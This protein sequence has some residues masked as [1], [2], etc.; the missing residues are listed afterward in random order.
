MIKPV[1]TTHDL[2]L[3]KERLVGLIRSNQEGSFTDEIEVLSTLIE[4]YERATIQIAAASPVEAIR[5][6][7]DQQGLAPRQLE[8]FIGSRARVSESLHLSA[9]SNHPRGNPCCIG[10]LELNV[11]HR[12]WIKERCFCGRRL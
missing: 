9:L 12:R 8:P 2:E 1:R 10:E 5:F 3:A 7:M 6:R 11:R 4:Q